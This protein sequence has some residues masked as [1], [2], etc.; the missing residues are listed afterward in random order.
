MVYVG[1]GN[2]PGEEWWVAAVL[3][4]YPPGSELHQEGAPLEINSYLTNQP[5]LQA[6]QT[7]QSLEVGGSAALATRT[8][9][10]SNGTPIG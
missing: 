6:G 9:V 4:G 1:P 2:T 8:G 5:G 10:V 7:G 3:W